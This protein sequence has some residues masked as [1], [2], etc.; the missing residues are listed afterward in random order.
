[1]NKLKFLLALSALLTASL[2]CRED[3]IGD[4][5]RTLLD[6]V[7]EQQRVTLA[8]QTQHPELYDQSSVEFPMAGTLRNL[9]AGLVIDSAG[10]ESKCPHGYQQLTV[11]TPDGSIL[12]LECAQFSV[13]IRSGDRVSVNTFLEYGEN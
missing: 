13:T 5:P 8:H 1:M 3:V 10:R 2:A 6:A 9:R 12:G 7:Q 11:T 4:T